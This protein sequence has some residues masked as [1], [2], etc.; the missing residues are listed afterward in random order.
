[1]SGRAGSARF[2][3]PA[4]SCRRLARALVTALAL[5]GGIPPLGTPAA[6]QAV[7]HDPAWLLRRAD[8]YMST[9]ERWRG[10][11]RN[12]LPW[13]Q[14]DL[15]LGLRSGGLSLSAG[16]WGALE[17]GR[18]G[19]EPRPDLRAGALGPTMATAWVQATAA[20]RGFTLSFG[21]L[22]DWFRRPG[23]DP[24]VG[25]IYAAAR[26]QRDRWSTAAS[27]WR[28]VSGAHGTYVE[29]SAAFHH[30]VNPFTGPVASW[31]S[32]VRA[33]IQ[34]GA[35]N[36]AGGASVPGP[37]GTGLT[38]LAL[39]TTLRGALPLGWDVALVLSTGPELQYR[40]DPAARRRRDGSRGAAVGLWWPLQVGLSYPVR[41]PE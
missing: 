40:R 5:G 28:A 41:R 18:T 4:S 33:G 29:P 11:R 22:R 31:S 23:R 7:L 26:F 30:F 16:A 6:A 37:A 9:R 20:K 17:T 14:G 10:I 34:V 39:G 32:T 25:E 27:V 1:M 24:A 19:T 8:L 36:P 15:V 21:G 13:V 35:R 38:H 2:H 3:P 12:A